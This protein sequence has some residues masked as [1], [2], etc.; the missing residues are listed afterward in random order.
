MKSHEIRVP[1]ELMLAKIPDPYKLIWIAMKSFQGRGKACHASCRKIG[2]RCPKKDG[3]PRDRS[4]VHH[5]Q[6][7]LDKHGF[8]TM[9][10]DGKYVCITPSGVE[11]HST[12]TPEESVNDIHQVLN[13][14]QQGVVP[15]ST[16]VEHHSTPSKN[17]LLKPTLKTNFK[18]KITNGGGGIV[19][20]SSSDEKQSAATANFDF[21]FLSEKDHCYLPTIRTWLSKYPEP[22]PR[23]FINE[24]WDR[25]IISSMP[26][27][28]ERTYGWPLFVAGALITLDAALPGP[29]IGMLRAVLKRLQKQL[30]IHQKK[31]ARPAP[32]PVVSLSEHELSFLPDQF[33]RD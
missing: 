11:P 7:V 2:E 33:K 32:V 24:I 30:T 13:T 18:T 25:E 23:E 6:K 9:N 1:I 12:L 20:V 17:Q 21:D 22:S 28:L 8:L 5:A 3:T 16:G 19:N 27:T 14:I 31:T 26:E 29:N 4:H 10:K 15:H